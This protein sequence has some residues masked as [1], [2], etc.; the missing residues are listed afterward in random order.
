MKFRL[1]FVGETAISLPVQYKHVIHAAFLRWLQDE[2][3]TSFLHGE[4]Y[5]TGKRVYKLYTISDILTKGERNPKTGKLLFQKG[6]ELVISSFTS[7]LDEAVKNAVEEDHPFFL[8]QTE[9]YVKDYEVIEE[10]AEDCI[11]RTLSPVTVHSSFELPDGSKK[12]YYYS[13]TEKN[14]AQQ[15]RENIFRKYRTIYG[16]DPEE[17]DFS[18]IPI[19]RK[20]MR[21]VIIQY[22][23][24]V[25]V[26]WKGKFKLCGNQELIRI[27]LLCGLGARNSIGMGAVLQEPTGDRERKIDIEAI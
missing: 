1:L 4:G 12:T 18:V 3:V 8:G 20:K 19:D 15:I 6:I 21:K 16:V 11:V 7:D 14:F 13:A 22:K 17:T 10:I 27:A 5:H 25:V 23:S 2:E 26:G 24:T 9:L